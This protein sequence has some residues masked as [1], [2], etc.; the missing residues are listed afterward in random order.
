MSLFARVLS[1]S[2]VIARLSQAIIHGALKSKKTFRP[3]IVFANDNII[4][5]LD[6]KQKD[7][8]LFF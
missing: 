1:A 8:K 4:L 6:W 2:G 7:A 5:Y 3:V